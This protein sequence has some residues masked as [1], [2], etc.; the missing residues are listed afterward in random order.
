M[1][2]H[3]L[4][5]TMAC[6]DV[7][8][9][10]DLILYET[11]TQ[12]KSDFKSGKSS[13]DKINNFIP[14]LPRRDK[15]YNFPDAF[16]EEGDSLLQ[17][18]E[19]QH[20]QEIHRDQTKLKKSTLLTSTLFELGMGPEYP[21]DIAGDGPRKRTFDDDEY[22]PKLV[23]V[24][25]IRRYNAKRKRSEADRK[26]DNEKQNP[27]RS[28]ADRKADNEKQNPKRSKAA[29]KAERKAASKKI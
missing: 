19:P 4:I 20:S 8:I 24:Q 7:Q 9:V 11:D 25:Q 15:E 21:S 26:A 17:F 23:R 28:K 2:T 22:D 16:Y 14:Y 18:T 12:C 5:L 13:F 10:D 29:R 3:V 27:K 6:T 1:G